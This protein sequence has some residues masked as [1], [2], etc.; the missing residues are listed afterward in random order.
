MVRTHAAE[1]AL[2]EVSQQAG[3]LSGHNNVLR[4]DI[5][6]IRYGTPLF[7]LSL[8]K[9]LFKILLLSDLAILL[10]DHQNINDSVKPTRES[11]RDMALRSA[12]IT[13]EHLKV[14]LNTLL[15]TLLS[16]SFPSVLF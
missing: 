4:A 8:F 3:L 7:P 9:I 14:Q 6:A 16:P 5:D 2:A 12:E 10:A 15:G 1:L 11:V 13:I